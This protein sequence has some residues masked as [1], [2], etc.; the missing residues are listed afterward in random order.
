MDL[1]SEFK[2]ITIILILNLF[3]NFQVELNFVL[4]F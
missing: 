4:K 3:F 2:K 1:V